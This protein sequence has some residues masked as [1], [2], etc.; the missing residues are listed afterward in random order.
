M[1]TSII[2][3]VIVVTSAV[4]AVERANA[5]PIQ[6]TAGGGGNDHWYEL[7]RSQVSWTAAESAAGSATYLGLDGHLATITSEAENTFIRDS[8]AINEL[9]WIGLTDQDSEGSFE[10][11][12]GETVSYSNWN[13]GE[14]NNF[15][16]IE[17]YAEFIGFFGSDRG[18]WN[19][20]SDLSGGGRFYVVEYEAVSVPEPGTLALLLSALLIFRARRLTGRPR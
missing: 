5:V 9:A 12:T 4:L 18:E 13:S 10:W 6:W 20:L 3:A 15:G 2:A 17:H 11:V 19:D 1:R 8:I 16:G 7:V 14:P